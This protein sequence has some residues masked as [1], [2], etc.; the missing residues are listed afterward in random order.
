MSD[1][2]QRIWSLHGKT[3][4]FVTHSIREAVILS[5]RVIVMGTGPGR[6]TQ[7]FAIDLAR[8]RT[9]S[10]EANTRFGAL[11]YEVREAISRGR[12]PQFTDPRTA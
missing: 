1:E 5:D 6:I 4:V 9:A 8:P 7:E 3:V 2:L 11:V 10:I 12:P